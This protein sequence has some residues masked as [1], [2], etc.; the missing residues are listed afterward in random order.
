MLKI[1]MI[2]LLMISM[3][4]LASCGSDRAGGNTDTSG[5][6]GA[7]ELDSD[8]DGLSDA[9]EENI[10]GTSPDNNDSDGDGLL[11]A[12]EIRYG[13]SLDS[14]DSDGDGLLDGDEIHI[15]DT[16][17]SNPDTDNDGLKDG[18][19]IKIYDTNASNPDTDN[20]GLNDEDE[21]KTYDTNASNPDTDGDCLLDSFEI[22]NYHT[23]ANNADTDADGVEDGFEIYGSLTTSCIATPETLTIGE[24]PTPAQDNLTNPDVI[25][26]LDPT[27]D[28]DGD[29]WANIKEL[30]CTGGNGKDVNQECHSIS[31]TDEGKAL[32]NYGYAF[33]PGGFDVDG[34]GINE[35]GFWTSVY[36]ATASYD[37]D[38]A[39]KVII[40]N[41]LIKDKIGANFQTYMNS[42]VKII[43]TADRLLTGYSSDVL[44]DSSDGCKLTFKQTELL[45][46]NGSRKSTHPRYTGVTPYM[47]LVELDY[48]K[49]FDTDSNELGVTIKMLSNKQYA[50]IL[51]LLKKD[52]EVNGENNVSYVPLIRNG[53]LGIDTNVPLVSY[54][55]EIKEFDENNREMVRDVMK[56]ANDQGDFFQ[57]TD[58]QSWWEVGNTELTGGN[59]NRGASTHDIGMGAGLTRDDNVMLVRGGELLDL[60]YGLSGKESGSAGISFR[61]ATDYLY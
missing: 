5:V 28:S 58:I 38:I 55:L 41:A 23:Q 16:N 18:D 20:D 14:N 53:L 15:Y 35:G 50:H 11:D 7:L 26:A 32:A 2:I 13:T 42:K 37:D 17:A 25:D 57:Q 3:L 46:N 9:D 45:E 43:N 40:S 34:D 10:Y 4:L 27:N 48:V 33:I 59:N 54:S 56:M 51:K 30:N 61:A 12:D 21:V 22:N 24:N 6:L 8:G 60:R 39:Q 31:D 47:A 49:F 1:R 36:Q 29:D 44:S 19:E 52:K